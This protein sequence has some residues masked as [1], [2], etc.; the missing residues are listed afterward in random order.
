MTVCIDTNVLVQARA[1]SHPFGVILDGFLFG[2]MNW[3]VSNRTLT[4]YEEIISSNAGPAAWGMVAR[5]IELVGMSGNLVMVSPHYQFH[6][7]GD[8][9]DDNAFTDCAIAAHAD[10]VITED[11]HFAALADAGYKPQPITP[12]EFIDRYR[13]IH[14]P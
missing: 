10:F 2:M 14:V 12:Q 9:P 3:A 7:I 1:N 13:G 5:F 11:R 4:E 6:I 8:D